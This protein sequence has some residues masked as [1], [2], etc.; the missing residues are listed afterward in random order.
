MV[1]EVGSVGI[2]IDFHGK[3]VLAVLK[4][5]CE[6]KLGRGS[7]V[8]GIAYFFAIEPKIKC[9]IDAAKND[10]GATPFPFSG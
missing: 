3:H 9:R 1:L 5:G 4:I 8:F 10:G 7:R 2:L 6:I